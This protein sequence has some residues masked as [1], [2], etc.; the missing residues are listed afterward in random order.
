[1]KDVVNTIFDIM[2]FNPKIAFDTSK[3]VGVV[4]R[5]LDITRAKKLLGWEPEVSLNEGL[6]RKIE[7]YIK[8]HTRRGFVNERLLMEHS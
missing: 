6:R 1:M 8:T 4:S 3:P 7:G 2:D 5:A